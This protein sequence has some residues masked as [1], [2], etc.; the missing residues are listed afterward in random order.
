MISQF[1]N[2]AAR[3]GLS[4]NP[5]RFARRAGDQDGADV[6]GEILCLSFVG[7]RVLRRLRSSRNAGSPVWGELAAFSI[8]FALAVEEGTSP[9][10]YRATVGSVSDK[11]CS[12]CKGSKV[13]PI[14][15]NSSTA[16]HR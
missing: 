13:A 1:R 10:A 2:S 7:T 12:I 9:S 4:R 3:G 15:S 11:S 8:N 16:R 5:A 6:G 14:S